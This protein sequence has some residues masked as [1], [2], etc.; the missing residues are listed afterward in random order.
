MLAS[1]VR[2]VKKIDDEPIEQTIIVRRCNK[3]S[4]MELTDQEL[5]AIMRELE[6]T[7]EEELE[8]LGDEEMDDE[9]VEEV[10]LDEIPVEDEEEDEYL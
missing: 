10:D 6:D 5:E 9:E 3:M 4:E 2:V 7:P 8:Y 1:V